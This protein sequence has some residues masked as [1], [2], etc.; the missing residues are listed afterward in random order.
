MS[1]TRKD[2]WNRVL[3]VATVSAA[4]AAAETPSTADDIG[5]LSAHTPAS[6][7]PFFV[8]NCD[9]HVSKMAIE[10]IKESWDAAFAARGQESPILLVLGQGMVLSKADVTH[11]LGKPQVTFY[12]DQMQKPPDPDAIARAIVQHLRQSGDILKE[13]VNGYE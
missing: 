4:A 7:I 5:T 8:L 10:K 9:V 3:A 11:D 1:L 6:G 2:F 12:V 13:N